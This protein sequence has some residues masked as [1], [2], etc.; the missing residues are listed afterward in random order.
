MS[1]GLEYLCHV[2]HTGTISREFW[3]G[4]HAPALLR[5]YVCRGLGPPG[6]GCPCHSRGPLSHS[7][8]DFFPTWSLLQRHVWLAICVIW[9]AV[10]RLGRFQK[11]GWARLLKNNTLWHFY[12]LSQTS[13]VWF[14]FFFFFTAEVGRLEVEGELGNFENIKI[15][16]CFN[17][18]WIVDIYIFKL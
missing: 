3:D 12:P 2:Y 9:E 7:S 18:H 1:L 6:V 5:V 17:F 8:F 13:D 11:P 16:E 15:T 14:F 4:L 10:K